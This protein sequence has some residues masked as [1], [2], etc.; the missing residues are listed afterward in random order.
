MSLNQDAVKVAAETHNLSSA[1]KTQADSAYSE[2]IGS[3]S[4]IKGG[5]LFSSGASFSG[6][7]TTVGINEAEIPAMKNAVTEYIDRL[8]Q[9]LQQVQTEADTSQAFKG[10]Y[11]TAIKNFVESVCTSCRFII[12][13]L[14]AVNDDLDKVMASYREKDAGLAGDLNSNAGGVE[15]AFTEYN[16]GK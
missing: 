6:S 13:N 12:S 14:H 4:K 2:I 9:H 11:S 7:A 8:N 5:G 1:V 16:S 10:D 15:S 3:A